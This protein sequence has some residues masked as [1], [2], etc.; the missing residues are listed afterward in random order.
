MDMVDAILF[1]LIVANMI[2]GQLAR[3]HAYKV[4][5]AEGQ[6]KRA[7]KVGGYAEGQ[8]AKD[9]MSTNPVFNISNDAGDRATLWVDDKGNTRAQ[10]RRGAK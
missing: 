6:R 7:Y 4:G 3:K 2:V 1:V 5:Y 9:L 10:F 8:K